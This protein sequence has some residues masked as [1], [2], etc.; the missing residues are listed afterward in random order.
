MADKRALDAW[1][2]VIFTLTYPIP[3][4]RVPDTKQNDNLVK[5]VQYT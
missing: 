4:S 5:V 2:G 3:H 1:L